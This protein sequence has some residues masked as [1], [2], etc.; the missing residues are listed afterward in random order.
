MRDEIISLKMMLKEEK[1]KKANGHK[2]LKT[3]QNIIRDLKRQLQDCLKH[4]LEAEAYA[5]ELCWENFWLQHRVKEMQEN[6]TT[7]SLE[8]A[9]NK[10]LTF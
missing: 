1:S 4:V 7:V 2:N 6:A 8:A 3:D 5:E 9:R 10:A